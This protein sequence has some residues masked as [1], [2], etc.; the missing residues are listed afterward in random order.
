MRRLDPAACVGLDGTRCRGQCQQAKPDHQ[1]QMR[2]HSGVETADP[3]ANGQGVTDRDRKER[4]RG[5]G[6]QPGAA[7]SEQQH[8]A[9]RQQVDHRPDQVNG[10]RG[11]PDA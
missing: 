2:A 8:Q 6:D 4:Q 5:R 1:R 9:E 11:R 3:G 7:R 10:E